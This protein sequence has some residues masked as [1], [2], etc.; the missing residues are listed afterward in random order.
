MVVVGCT[1][2][3][4]SGKSTV[5]SLMARHGAQIVDADA[6]AHQVVAPG[7]AVYRAVVERFGSA[8]VAGDQP[9][10]RPALAAVVF[11][12][13]SARRDLEAIIHPAVEKVMLAQIAKAR[14]AGTDVIC[15]IP[16]LVETNARE[17]YGLDVVVVVDAPEEIVLERLVEQRGVSEADAK[18]RIRAQL[19]RFERLRS[20]DA[21]VENIGTFDELTE[22]V[23]EVW[24]W[25]DHLGSSSRPLDDSPPSLRGT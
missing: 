20:A 22:M 19:E 5:A 24:R 17:R 8:I 10:D 12:D 18:A 23:D 7:T 13:D 11:G 6:I 16:L 9:I 3:I 25:I 2:G 14:G 21:I 4:G 1:G 15:D